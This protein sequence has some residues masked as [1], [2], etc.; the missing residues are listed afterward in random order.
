MNF[1]FL[2]YYI[3]EVKGERLVNSKHQLLCFVCCLYCNFYFNLR[4]MNCFNCIFSHTKSKLK[5]LSHLLAK[6]T[7]DV[8]KE[9]VS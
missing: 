9:K 5:D 1:A 8:Q 3:P 7:Y 4:P 2:V 6:K